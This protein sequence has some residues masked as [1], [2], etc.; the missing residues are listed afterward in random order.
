MEEANLMNADI[1][2]SQKD[3]QDIQNE[4]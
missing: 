3:L 4:I 1:V 2:Y